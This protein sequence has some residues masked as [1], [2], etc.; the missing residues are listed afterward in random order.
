M[1]REGNI[2]ALSKIIEAFLEQNPDQEAFLAEQ[3]NDNELTASY[4]AFSSRPNLGMRRDHA[5]CYQNRKIMLGFAGNFPRGLGRDLADDVKGWT[6]S[7]RY[8]YDEDYIL[9]TI[10]GKADKS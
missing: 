5:D 2:F 4:R 7:E 9:Y 1:S 10:K 3:P 6:K 8:G